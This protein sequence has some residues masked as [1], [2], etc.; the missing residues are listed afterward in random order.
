[1][2]LT[3][4]AFTAL[5]SVAGPLK[6]APQVQSYQISVNVRSAGVPYR[7]NTG[8]LVVAFPPG[9][10]LQIAY[11]GGKRE[12]AGTYA[13]MS[14]LVA[15]SPRALVMN[16]GYYTN[17]PSSPAGLL[18]VNGRIFSPFNFSQSA[19]LCVD[20]SGKL[21][22]LRTAE[23]QAAA[24][25]IAKMCSDGLQSYPIV[26]AGGRNDIR[27]TELVRPA[28]RRSLI[29]LRKDGS[30]VAVFFKSPVH[31]FVASEF[32]RSRQVGAR[33]VQVA[34]E[35]GRAVSA[36]GGLGLVDAVNLS[37]DTDSFAALYG[38]VLTGDPNRH[39]PSA[40]VIK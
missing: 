28:Y 26:V 39:L 29:G 22:I 5:L 3:V 14:E 35:A 40:I 16:G 8:A 33:N 20:R 21:K 23:I 1:M 17:D 27:P 37:G 25:S 36:T 19:T 11:I 4:I 34:G 32:M 24:R 6:A 38:K 31:L 12:F 18:L 13:G 7:Y 30:V 10:Q 2:K 9:S 15:T